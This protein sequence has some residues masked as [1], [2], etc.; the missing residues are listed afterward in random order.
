[1]DCGQG[2][3]ILELYQRQLGLPGLLVDKVVVV[4]GR[5]VEAVP[6]L[7]VELRGVKDDGDLSLQHDKHHGV[8]VRAAHALGAVTLDPE[9]R[10]ERY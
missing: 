5:D 8:L 1:M 4:L 3:I 7:G 10:E 6:L 9:E 2:T